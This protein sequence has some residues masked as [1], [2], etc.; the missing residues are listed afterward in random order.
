MWGA[1][2]G[3]VLWLLIPTS[4][5]LDDD[6]DPHYNSDC[7]AATPARERVSEC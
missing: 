2:R 7:R 3:E 1:L 5:L 4:L 6:F